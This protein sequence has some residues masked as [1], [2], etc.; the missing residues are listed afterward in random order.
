[1]SFVI[2]RFGDAFA[3][4][5]ELPTLEGRQPQGAT[6]VTGSLTRLPGG[7]SFDWRGADA[8]GPEP[9]LIELFGGWVAGDVATMR[10][11]LA[12]LKSLVGRRSRLW[13]TDGVAHQWRLARCLRLDSD[14]EA[15]L[16]AHSEIRLSF[17][18]DAGPW[19]GTGRSATITLDTSPKSQAVT[20]GGNV[21]Q[22]DVVLTVTAVGSPI[23]AL[24]I[25][26]FAVGHESAIH[27]WG[28]IAAGQ[29]LVLDCG[30]GTVRNHGVD[31]Y[32][33]LMLLA[34]HTM[35]E[36]LRLAPGSNTIRVT[37]TGGGAASTCILAYHDA[38][39]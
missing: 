16:P 10:A 32:A 14:L 4:A 15:G 5:E 25:H 24:W 36:W 13:R 12:A 19:N 27:Y 11:K 1:M 39:A 35:R 7:G 34:G 17:E 9:D 29:A 23:T 3:T 33:R 2:R 31:D 26:N 38:W 21:I 30:A 8:A 28:A 37:R 18:L 6:A 20:N 22:R